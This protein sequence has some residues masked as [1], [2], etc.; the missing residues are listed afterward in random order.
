MKFL[1]LLSATT[2]VAFAAATGPAAQIPLQGMEEPTIDATRVIGNIPGFKCP[3]VNNE[4]G[5]T[6]HADRV[7]ERVVQA[8]EAAFSRLPGEMCPSNA[9]G[10]WTKLRPDS[11]RCL[12]DYLTAA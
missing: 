2:P 11:K 12:F 1:S 8:T 6:F 9:R 4:G 3:Q 5:G 7:R 10:L